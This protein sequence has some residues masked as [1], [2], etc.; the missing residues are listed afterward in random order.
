M[1]RRKLWMAVVLLSA[2]LTVSVFALPIS[3][4]TAGECGEKLTWSFDEETATLTIGGKGDMDSYFSAF[5]VPWYGIREEVEKIVIEK[6]VTSLDAHAFTGCLSLTKI[7]FYATHMKDLPEY[8]YAF[9]GAGE[10]S[11]GYTLTVGANV[12]RIPGGLFNNWGEPAYLTGV[13]FP[14]GSA[15]RE[16]GDNAFGGCELL[17]AIDLPDGIQRIGAGAFCFT[18]LTEIELGEKIT[19]IGKDAFSNVGF[20][21]ITIPDGVKTIASGTFNGCAELETVNL[22]KGVETIGD[23]AFGDCSSLVTL[24]LPAR[25]KTI[26]EHVFE[27]C[28]NLTTMIIPD[29]VTSIGEYAFVDCPN[30]KEVKLGKGL[31]TLGGSAFIGC[32]K[33]ESIE[34]PASLIEIHDSAFSQ[35]TALKE[36]VIP[37]SVTRIGSYAF[38]GCT[39]LKTITIGKGVKYL[40]DCAFEDC[41]ALTTIYFNA[42]EMKD[43]IS[44]ID[45]KIFA[46]AG[47]KGTG[48]Q[49]VVGANVT[50]IPCSLFCPDIYPINNTMKLKLV[51]VTFEEGS[52]CREIGDYA[53]GW[54]SSLVEVTLPDSLKTIGEDA[55]AS[56]SITSIAIPDSV[57]RI[58]NGAF[59]GCKKLATVS[60]TSPA[61]VT[62]MTHSEG[63][64]GMIQYAKTVLIGSSVTHVPDY[65]PGTYRYV[66]GVEQDGVSYTAYSQIPCATEHEHVFQEGFK[67]NENGHGHPCI[68]CDEVDELL[69]HEYESAC[70]SVCRDCGSI[71]EPRHS[72]YY[73]CDSLCTL[74][75]ATRKTQ[76][77]Y[78]NACDPDCNFCKKVRAVTHAYGDEWL[79]DGKSHWKA[80]TVC[81]E[82][83]ELASHSW[84]EGTVTKEPTASAEGE[85]TYICLCGESHTESLPKI[86]VPDEEKNS[87]LIIVIAIGAGLI[88]GLVVALVLGKKKKTDQH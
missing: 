50:R 47:I 52:V 82:K 53:F 36:I 33:L 57:T 21:E 15:C 23:Y 37:D 67:G 25:L 32:S 1:N 59:T 3:A 75:G 18:G 12:T 71:R 31:T 14:S 80:C 86:A 34:L 38:Y 72:Y 24:D 44:S 49:L 39:S 46:G 73:P 65:L 60:V 68:S 30:L 54:C 61:F 51:S 29:S 77:T 40:Y 74:C 83:G 7:E 11:D 87:G 27:A 17:E 8:N 63:G 43:N 16:I 45:F 13:V 76:H 58:G 88:A 85:K 70:E 41:T 5:D 79:A 20:T 19:E 2:L 10:G 26:G 64:F 42:T 9:T 35:C 6:N 62:E 28:F 69:P 78:E 55:F 48:I 84:G 4:E 22:G 66:Y 81:G 56:T